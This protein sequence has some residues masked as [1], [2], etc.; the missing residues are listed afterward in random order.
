MK[1][2]ILIFTLILTTSVVSAQLYEVGAFLGGS[3]YIGDIGPTTY[4][5]PNTIAIGGVA[6]FNFTPRITFRGTFTYTNLLMDDSKSN[7][8]FRSERGLYRRNKII[9]ASAGIEFSFFKYSMSKIGFS[10]TPYIIAQ[11]GAV[12]HGMITDDATSKRVTSLVIPFGFGYKMRLAENVGIALETTVRYT[13]KDVIDGNNH[14]IGDPYNFG[15]PNSD[16]WYVFTGITIVYAF[17][18]P[19]CY[20]GEF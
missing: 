19:G 3:N 2:Q 20:S 12:N 8:D 7:N 10:Q 1:K 18:R 11:V 4:I 13:L 17:G 15:N 16:D 9:D 6:K 14:N 5:N